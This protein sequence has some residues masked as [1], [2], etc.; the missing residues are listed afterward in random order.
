MCYGDKSAQP[1]CLHANVN[2]EALSILPNNFTIY[3]KVWQEKMDD[4]FFFFKRSGG[5]KIYLAGFRFIAADEAQMRG[6]KMWQTI[7]YQLILFADFFQ[8]DVFEFAHRVV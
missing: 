1:H 7:E 5:E 8:L 4:G 3:I 2:L 6:S